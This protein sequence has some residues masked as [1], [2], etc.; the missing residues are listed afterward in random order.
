MQ[1]LV[2]SLKLVHHIAHSMRSRY[3][4]HVEV[5]DLVQDG[6]IG[7]L[8]A[9]ERY[10]GQNE[11]PFTA[12]AGSRIRGAILDGI[13]SRDWVPRTLR[14]F[15]SAQRRAEQAVEVRKGDKPTAAEVAHEMSLSLDEYHR[16][17]AM[18]D[19]S[20]LLDIDCESDDSDH[21]QPDALDTLCNEE[22]DW[23][24]ANAIR[25]LSPRERYV[26]EQT[27]EEGR[28][29]RAVA[30]DMELTE[31]RVSQIRKRAIERLRDKLRD[32]L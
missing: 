3:P 16:Q 32:Y 14:K 23:A 22:F 8:Q 29:A 31:S 18:V 1:P 15:Q 6:C 7:L 17:L 2:D 11:V 19:Q 25:T 12:F 5:D 28:Y 20:A 10:E 26:L 9:M 4:A 13:R 27:V 21:D 24:M 30:K